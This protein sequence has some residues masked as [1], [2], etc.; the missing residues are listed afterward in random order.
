MKQLNLI[1]TSTLT[2]LTL[3]ACGTSTGVTPSQNS[4]LNSISNSSGKAKS[5]YMQK[6]LDTWLVE[7]WTPAV[8]QDKEIQEKYMER[9]E[10]NS[11]NELTK[12]SAV[13]GANASEKKVTYVEKKDKFPTLQEYVDKT[14]AYLKATKKDQ[15]PEASNVKK[16]EKMPV[17]GK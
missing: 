1:I 7:D 16:L 3:A 12:T 9:V 5:G 13:E 2:I 15:M 17:I 11:S 8:E 10:S 14:E 6:G 4:A